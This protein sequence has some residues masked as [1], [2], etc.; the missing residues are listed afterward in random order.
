MKKQ[1]N[2]SMKVYSQ[3][4]RNY[5]ATPTIILKGQWLEEMGFAI[6]DY[7]SVSCENGKLVI[8]PDTERAE[9]EQMKA[10]FMEKETKKLRKRFQREK[11]ELYAQFVAEKKAQYMAEKHESVARSEYQYENYGKKQK[12]QY[13]FNAIL[14]WTSAEVWLYI[15][16]KGIYVN[17]AY[18]KGNSRA[19]CLFCPMGGN[20]GDYIQ[21]CS[22][23]TEVSKY[24]DLIKS[25]DARDK[26]NENA[27]S[28][29]VS[30]G[31]WNARK[32]GRDL[33][34]NKQK[35]KDEVRDRKLIITVESPSTDWREWI[36]TLGQIPF[37]FSFEQTSEG[38][39]VSCDASLSKKYPKEGI[40]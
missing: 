35:Y 12:G 28:T 20:K 17:E 2:R 6:G 40:I 13:S 38:Y 27:L 39:V 23:P 16:A 32:N 25:M 4:G 7:I 3:N 24:V 31:G 37:D 36:K 19:G 22:Y 5:K 34:I 15:F 30:K 1:K 11:E 14:E 9:L 10:D 18:K 26:D 33:T 8:T 21:Y 29:Y